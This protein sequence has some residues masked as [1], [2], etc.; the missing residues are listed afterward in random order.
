[1]MAGPWNIKRWNT[2]G[3]W[4]SDAWW[5]ERKRLDRSDAG[6]RYALILSIETPGQE[7]DIWTPVAVQAGVVVEIET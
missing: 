2:S 5:K 1:M 4:R 7:T 6:T 3:D